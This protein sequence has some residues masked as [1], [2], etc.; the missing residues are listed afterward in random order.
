MHETRK[1][2]DDLI[3]GEKDEL[4]EELKLLTWSCYTSST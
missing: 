4:I 3:N 2:V 1:V